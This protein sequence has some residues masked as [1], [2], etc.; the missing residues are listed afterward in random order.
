MKVFVI[1]LARSTERRQLMTEKMAAAGVEFEF[2]DAIDAAVPD[3]R[4]SERAA[5]NIT[6]RRKGYELLPS[7]IAC[8]ASHFRLWQ[9]CIEL[10]EP[11]V[12]LEDNIDLVKEFKVVLEKTFS[13]VSEFGYIK[14]AATK[15]RAFKSKANVDGTH[16][17]GVYKKGTCGTTG[18]IITPEVAARFISCSDKFIEPVDDFMEKPWIHKVQAYSLKPSICLRGEVVSTIGSGRKKKQKTGMVNKVFIELFRCCESI[19]HIYY[20]KF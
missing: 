13:R 8:Y 19:M 3:F 6:K 10:N 4:L 5:P 12:I 18:Y 7:E 16:Q 20:W 17:I 15:P 1:N 9:Q 14:L 2:F 11:L